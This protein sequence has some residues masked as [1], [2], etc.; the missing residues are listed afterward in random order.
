MAGAGGLTPAVPARDS[1]PAGGAGLRWGLAG[2]EREAAQRSFPAAPVPD[3]GC[4]RDWFLS[5]GLPDWIAL[6]VL[7][8][9]R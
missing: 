3:P 4:W 2:A 8:V 1:Q 7:A 6:A 9:P 5:F